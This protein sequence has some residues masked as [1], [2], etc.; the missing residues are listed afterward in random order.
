MKRWTVNTF[1]LVCYIAVI[2]AVVV[3]M[4]RVRD[5]QL[6]ELQQ[7][8]AQGDWQAWRDDVR[9]SQGSAPVERRIPKSSEPPLLVLLRDYYATCLTAAMV[10]TSLLFGVTMF[11]V[12]GALRTPAH[13]IR[14]APPD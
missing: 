3:S 7:P 11:F 12:R 10:F 1:W 14:R 5:S 9:D 8:A 4:G 13:P 2:A 6:P